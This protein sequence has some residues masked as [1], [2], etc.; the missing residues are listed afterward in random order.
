MF[1]AHWSK[2][3]GA[4]LYSFWYR[5]ED[6]YRHEEIPD[7]KRLQFRQYDMAITEYN[8]TGWWTPVTAEGSTLNPDDP[9]NHIMQLAVR[10]SDARRWWVES[11]KDDAIKVML[12]LKNVSSLIDND[13]PI[14]ASKADH[15][16]TPYVQPHPAKAPMPDDQRLPG[17]RRR[18]L[19]ILRV[20]SRR[21]LRNAPPT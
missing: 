4:G 20:V 1:K 2:H 12:K 14:A 10:S 11:F 6:R 15:A 13:A 18:L 16:S 7:I 5:Q 3:A 17:S 8:A 19:C 9:W 21:H